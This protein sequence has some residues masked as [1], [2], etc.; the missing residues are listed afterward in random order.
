[1]KSNAWSIQTYCQLL[2]TE[3]PKV[4]KGKANFLM[5]FYSGIFL[6]R[7]NKNCMPNR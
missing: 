4:L 6:S 2:L 3:P 5:L 7:E 1:M